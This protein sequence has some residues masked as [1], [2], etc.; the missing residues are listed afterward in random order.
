MVTDRMRGID[1]A[2]RVRGRTT[3]AHL[4]LPV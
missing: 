1:D 3:L 2:A 4:T